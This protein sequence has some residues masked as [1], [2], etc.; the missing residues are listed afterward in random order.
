M[1]RS[2]EGEEGEWM[3]MAMMMM[4]HRRPDDHHHHH[5]RR[6]Q[7]PRNG[8]VTVLYGTVLVRRGHRAV[9]DFHVSRNVQLVN[10]LQSIETPIKMT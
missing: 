1:G 8:M 4:M 9:R 6:R 3:M 10:S 2:E 7:A 5:Q